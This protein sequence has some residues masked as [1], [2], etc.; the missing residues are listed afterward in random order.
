MQQEALKVLSGNCLTMGMTGKEIAE[1]VA[2]SQV[3][4]RE[5][6]SG[7]YILEDGERPQRLYILVRGAVR[8]LKDTASGREILLAE[9]TEPG[10]MFGEV[11]L[12]IARQAYDMSVVAMGATR[13]LTISNAMFSLEQGELAHISKVLLQNLLRIFA[14]KAYF[15]HNRLKVLASG[16]LRGK[17]VRYLFQLPAKDQRLLLPGSRQELADYLAVTRP[18][19]SR[20]LS[21]MQADG[22]LEVQGRSVHI[23]DMEAFE[24]CL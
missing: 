6:G 1:L 14:S 23:L 16:S 18:S 2:S 17:L 11:Y 21:A 9:I 24:A 12:F 13:V 8:I 22:I 7:E 3:Q 5:F 4:L 10:E 15:M 19:L 20:E